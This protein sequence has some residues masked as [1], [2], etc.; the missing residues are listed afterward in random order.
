MHSASGSTLASWL[1]QQYRVRSAKFSTRFNC[2]IVHLLTVIYISAL[3]Q[4]HAW[5]RA[6]SVV[7]LGTKGWHVCQMCITRI[8][9]ISLE[10]SSLQFTSLAAQCRCS[11][12]TS[13]SSAA[14]VREINAPAWTSDTRG[15]AHRPLA[16]LH[17]SPR[18]VPCAAS[19]ES[20]SLMAALS[21]ELKR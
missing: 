5:N 13:S 14:A 9:F 7:Q 12:H 21:T 18:T 20:I 6:Q 17:V 10:I 19:N 8:Q 1:A 15:T 11:N 2:L 3:R 16:Q 4:G